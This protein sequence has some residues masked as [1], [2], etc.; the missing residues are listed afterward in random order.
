MEARHR[1]T[2]REASLKAQEAEL[3]MLQEELRR[4]EE[5]SPPEIVIQR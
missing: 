2:Q 5:S 3:Q 1:K 4:A